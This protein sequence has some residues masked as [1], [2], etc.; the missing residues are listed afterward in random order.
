MSPELLAM[1]AV[2]GASCLVC[3]LIR[4]PKLLSKVMPVCA[5]AVAVATMWFLLP[6]IGG[7]TYDEGMFYVDQLS[8]LFM[9]LVCIVGLGASVY[10]YA[11][12]G[13]DREEGELLSRQVSTYYTLLMLFICIMIAT[14]AV[15]SMA[16]VWLGVGATTLVSTFLVGIYTSNESN[17]AAWKYII[18][19]S[20]GITVALAGLVLVYASTVGAIDSSLALDW[21]S[22]MEAADKL[23]PNLMKMGTALVILGFGTKVGFVPMH[24]WLPDAHSQAPSPV[25]GLL[26]AV[27]L[28]CAMYGVIRFYMVSEIAVPGFASTILLV[29]GLIS[30]AVAAF[31]IVQARD[32]KRMLAY[33]SIENMGLIAIGLGIGSPL[34]ITAAL[35]QLAAHS[36]TK[37][38][39]FFSAGSIVQTYGTR[40]MADIHGL[41]KA[42]PFSS[43]ALTAGVLA[44]IGV[45]P[46]AIF[47]GEFSLLSAAVDGYVWV[48]AIVIAMLSIVAAGF[49]RNLVSMRA[50]EAPEGRHERVGFTTIAPIGCLIALSLFLGLF[51]PDGI[52]D[53]VDSIVALFG[54][55]RYGDQLHDAR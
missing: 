1:L 21:T 30:L 27:L 12:I 42:A 53:W 26:S 28:N 6:V 39:L 32:L 45:P 47:V 38:I 23:D 4:G 50:G 5:L 9:S 2:M 16:V 55:I 8:A 54:G 17:E 46:F 43:F 34:A 29:F 48:A 14:F 40:T 10:S 22:L 15:R 37:P 33:S 36:I 41:P 19:C 49:V 13:R 44:I 20:V 25:S 24:T 35:L 11:Y 31:L 7:E 52:R 3:F 18:L 51:M